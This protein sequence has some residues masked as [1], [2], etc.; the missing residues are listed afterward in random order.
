MK[1]L[2]GSQLRQI[3]AHTIENEPISS[4]S[5]MERAALACSN[6]IQNHIS[7]D[8]S[9][10]VVC[11]QGNNGGDGLAIARQLKEFGYSVDVF[12]VQMGGKSSP[13]FS[14]N[15]EQLSDVLI[16][17]QPT[18]NVNFDVYTHLI[19]S[20]FGVGINRPVE[21][22]AADVIQKMNAS[23]AQIIS[24]DLPSGLLSDS[25][26]DNNSF[27][28]NSDICLTLQLPKLALLLP[29]NK[30][31]VQHIEIVPIGLDESFIQSQ[32]TDNYFVDEAM[33]KT[34]YLPR[35]KHAHKGNFGHA[36][37]VAGS[38]GKIGA[39]VLAT[40]ACLRAGAGLVTALVPKIGYSI[41]Q[42]TIPEAMVVTT[43]DEHILMGTV[44][45]NDR[46]V[47]VGPGIG[48]HANTARFLQH[49]LRDT[50]NPMVI[51]ADAI[52]LLA[53]NKA[54][55]RS[56]PD[57]SILTP[58]P[59]ELERLIGEWK[60]DYDKLARV[61]LFCKNNDV[62]VVI[63]GVHTA[64]VDPRN[65][66]Y[67]NSTG[68]PGMATAGSGDVLTGIITGLL[69]QGYS[70]LNACVLGVYLHGY[71]DDIAANEHGQDALIAS[72]LI[73]YLGKAFQHI[74]LH[75]IKS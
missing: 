42:S 17:D 31:F 29:D 30:E 44:E 3:D 1:I 40:T 25:K 7:T 59:K 18:S 33:A 11:G 16:I 62:Y 74:Q 66:V 54:W 6:W 5:L 73:Q 65:T 50:S 72:D 13:D 68:N 52:N 45:P 63:K 57:H 23:S 20:L 2:N 14:S 49:L 58:H 36:M 56:I 27:V 46:T 71:A 26:Q 51:D 38:Y 12:V 55:I 15:L 32:P 64:I 70:S 4:L 37:M 39:A 22:L 43:A 47:A 60:D 41:L 75:G 34:M 9:F 48:L 21:G 24:I 35:N 19:D 10:G 8:A 61:K 69:T 28:V 53:E 67:F